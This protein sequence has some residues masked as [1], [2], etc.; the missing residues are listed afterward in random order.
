M[1][2]EVI[3]IVVHVLIVPQLRTDV[4]GPICIREGCSIISSIIEIQ[5]YYRRIGVPRL[6]K[7][8]GKGMTLHGIAWNDTHESRI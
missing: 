7:H 5:V 4:G 1:I 2:A 6:V 3:I 8:I